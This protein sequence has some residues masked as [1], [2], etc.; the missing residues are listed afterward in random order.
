MERPSKASGN[1]RSA[2]SAAN[3]EYV[4]K[5]SHC[6]EYALCNRLEEFAF[7]QRLSVSSVIEFS[8]R[9][10]FEMDEDEK[11]GRLL[12]MNGAR[13]RRKETNYNG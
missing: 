2:F 4:A 12:R 13:R 9:S 1:A 8:L 5:V 3:G 6:L 11:L 7:R 10:F